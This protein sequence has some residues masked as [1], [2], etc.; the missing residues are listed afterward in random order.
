MIPAKLWFIAV[1]LGLLVGVIAYGERSGWLYVF[2]PQ[3]AP[4]AI[5]SGSPGR[6]LRISDGDTVRVRYHDMALSIRLR[7]VD[8]EESVHTDASK[9]TAFGAATSKWAKS[10]L[11]RAECYVEFDRDG[12]QIDTDHHG[13]ALGLLWIARGEPGP[14]DDE[15]YNETLIRRGYSKYVTKYGNAGK[16]HNRLLQAERQARKEKIG[17]WR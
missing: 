17:V 15:L 9:N 8:T 12:W 7:N 5:M 16:Y 13:R 2:V 1:P 14:G 4:P 6:L 3:L 11:G 10:Y